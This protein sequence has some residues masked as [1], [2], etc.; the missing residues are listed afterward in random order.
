MFSETGTCTTKFNF[1]LPYGKCKF[2]IVKTCIIY[3]IMVC[4]P[5]VKII[6]SVKLV[7]YLLVPVD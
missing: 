3:E 6:Y 7:D 4:P 1:F 5:V 2:V